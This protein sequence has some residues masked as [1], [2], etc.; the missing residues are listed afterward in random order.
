VDVLPRRGRASHR[1][2]PW[3]R[4]RD[5]VQVGCPRRRRGRRTR[6]AF[7]AGTRRRAAVPR[8]ERFSPRLLL[9]RKGGGNAPG[10]RTCSEMKSGPV[11]GHDPYLLMV[12]VSLLTHHNV[13]QNTDMSQGRAR[14]RAGHIAWGNMLKAAASALH[15]ALEAVPEAA[16]HDDH[17]TTPALELLAP[18]TGPCRTPSLPAAPSVTRQSIERAPAGPRTPRTRCPPGT[19][20]RRQGP[21]PTELT[22]RGPPPAQDGQRRGSP[23]SSKTCWAKLDASEQDQMRRPCSPRASPH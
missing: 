7:G 8:R 6:S 2:I 23:A 10:S 1:A 3:P 19:G 12:Y 15:S 17:P 14:N 9:V 4:L 16:R 11:T 21:L 18:A 22:A 5:R 20:T 13:C